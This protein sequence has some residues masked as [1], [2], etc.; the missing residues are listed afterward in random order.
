MPSPP[1]AA[2]WRSIRWTL[3]LL[4]V[5]LLLIVVT[6]LGIVARSQLSGVV[7][8]A[9]GDRL[10]GVTAQLASMLGESAKRSDAEMVAAAAD[11][12]LAAYLQTRRSSDSL[13]AIRSLSGRA[14]R[15][16]AP[17]GTELRTPSGER[18]L[19]IGS[20]PSDADVPRGL[21]SFGQSGSLL[22]VTHG[23]AVSAPGDTVG[24]LVQYR[25]VAGQGVATVRA[26]IGSHADFLVGN[27]DASLWTDLD[28]VVPG[29]P[30]STVAS[31]ALGS[32]V[33]PD[34]EQ[35]VGMARTIPGTPM[36]VW[37]E[38]PAEVVMAPVQAFARRLAVA[39]LIVIA[40]GALGGW[41][42]SR[43]LTIPLEERTEELAA[44]LT[45][46]R[47]AQD[48][49]VKRE[50]MA[51]LGQ[52]A[53]GVGHELRN[54]LGVMSNAVHYLTAVLPNRSTEV[55]D[56]FGILR[57]QIGLAERIVGDLLDFARVKTPLRERVALDHVAAEQIERMGPLDGIR[58]EQ[59]WTAGLPPAFV[60]RVQIGQVVLNLIANAVQAM[61]DGG[62]LTLRG[63][64]DG[65]S[66]VRLD[67]SDTGSGIAGENLE[68]IFEPLFTTKARGLGLGLAVSRA[69]AHA[70]GGEIRVVESVV[71]KGS[72]FSLVLPT[73]AG[74]AA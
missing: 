61:G 38:L 10:R 63:S 57:T 35:K 16:S 2:P 41:L 47:E 73:D 33:R 11:P 5:G 69:L 1:S 49:L 15:G 23:T 12:A 53:A 64:P 74:A 22:Y 36:K 7:L 62:T 25:R 4:I 59:H 18:V 58:V 65:D 21:G 70:N 32:Y 14:W 51:M 44:A 28:K 56:Y 31:N 24:W 52:L 13:R 30:A 71:G 67:V 54:P 26:L 66:R 29:P 40:A 6:T 3:P 43:R 50:R 39:A 27:A 34:G 45:Q 55:D 42:L 48:E 37:T 60:D 9:T 46:L 17:L 68:R 19:S 8:D 20:P 72:T